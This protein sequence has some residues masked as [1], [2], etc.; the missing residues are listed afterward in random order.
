MNRFVVSLL[1]WIVALSTPI[2]LLLTVSHAM[3][4]DW[5]P[6]YEYSKPDF[7]PDGYGWTQ[8]ERLDLVLPSIHFLNSPLPPEQAIGILEAQR[9]PGSNALLFTPNE[10][11]HMVDVK[12]LVDQLWRVQLFAAILFIGSLII[13]FVRRDT[14]R[15]AYLALMAGGI[16]TT[17]LLVVLGI[18]VA[19]GFDQ[20]FVQFHELF[21]P[22][23]NWTFDYSDSLI[24]LLPEKLWFDGGVMITLGTFIA[25]LIVGGLGFLGWRLSAPKGSVPET[26][27]ATA[28]A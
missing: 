25:G 17:A 24:R 23:G 19:A 4:G 11:S 15:S 6:R 27:T 8:G 9:Q 1:R 2:L 12:R 10:L 28:H 22:Q 26:G 3:F 7:P 13:L 14:R 18:F 16:L 21:F 20:L 5:F